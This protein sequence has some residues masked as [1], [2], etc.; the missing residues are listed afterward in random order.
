M[1]ATV[2]HRVNLHNLEVVVRAL[3]KSAL[4]VVINQCV[5]AFL[6]STQLV[7]NLDVAVLVEAIL[8]RS[9]PVPRFPAKLAKYWT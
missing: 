3:G 6:S 4:S 8:A 5:N 7:A 9:S 1:T 2:A